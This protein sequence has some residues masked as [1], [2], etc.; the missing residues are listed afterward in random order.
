MLLKIQIYYFDVLKKSN[1]T[2]EI[3]K[4]EEIESFSK[5]VAHETNPNSNCKYSLDTSR[6]E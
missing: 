1:N 3:I 4:V 5:E 2:F 6:Y